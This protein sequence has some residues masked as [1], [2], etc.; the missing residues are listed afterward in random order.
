[1]PASGS[2]DQDGIRT[3]CSKKQPNRAAET[4]HGIHT[5]ESEHSVPGCRELELGLAL[6]GIQCCC[7]L[8][9]RLRREME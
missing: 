6:A 9:G 2:C 5:S 1:M 3:H 4:E 8:A 7:G